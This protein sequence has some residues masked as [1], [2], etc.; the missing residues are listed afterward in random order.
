MRQNAQI[1]AANSQNK[2]APDHSVPTGVKYEEYQA[3]TLGCSELKE[4]SQLSLCVSSSS[5]SM[6]SSSGLHHP[7]IDLALLACFVPTFGLKI[8]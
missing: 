5:F 1:A 3:S 4:M 6:I 8:S 2:P 7:F